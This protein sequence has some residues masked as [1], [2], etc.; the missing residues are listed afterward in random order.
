[1]ASRINRTRA[2][3]RLLC[4]VLFSIPTAVAVVALSGA[5]AANAA[6]GQLTGLTLV[7]TVNHVDLHQLTDNS[8]VD[9]DDYTTSQ[10][11]IRADVTS[12]DGIGS[13]RLELTGPTSKSQTENW[14]PFSLYGDH[15][16]K[17]KGKQLTAGDYRIEATAYSEP[18]LGGTAL[19]TLSVS[20]TLVETPTVRA[21]RLADGTEH[22]GRLEIFHDGQWGTVC[23]DY[24]GAADVAVACRQ[25]GYTKG[26][27]NHENIYPFGTGPIWLDDVACT[28]SE[29][30]LSECRHRAYGANNCFHY[31]DMEITCANPLL[32]I[33][34]RSTILAPENRTLVATLEAVT[35][36]SGNND[37]TWT[38]TGGEDSG[39]FDL[40]S[41]GVLSFRTLQD[42]EAPDDSDSDGRYEVTVQV[43]GGGESA[44]AD[45]TVTLQASDDGGEEVATPL[46]ATFPQSTY[47]TSRHTGPTDR[48]QVVVAFSEA[49]TTIAA[50]TPSAVVTGATVDALAA[51]TEDGL[52]NAWVFFLTPEGNGD[53]TFTLT[54]GVACD[55][56]GICTAAGTTLTEV[57]APRTVPGPGGDDGEGTSS[58]DLT[59]SFSSMPSEHGGPGKL[60]TFELTFNEAPQ[61]GYEKLRDHAFTVSGG[62]VR[63][64]QRL[65]RPSNIRWLITVEP[66]GWGDVSLTLPGGRACTATGAICTDD[67]RMLANSPNA[68]VQGSAALYVAD[69]NAVEGTD[70]MLDFAVILDRASTL[71]VTVDYAT[72]NGTATEDEDYTATSGR[73]TFAPGDIAK[74]VSVPVLNDAKDEGHQETM[75]LTLSNASNARIADGTATGTIANS[76]PLQQAWIARFGRTVASEIVDGITDRLATTGGGSE[77]RIAGVTL[78]RDGAS[79]TE[80]D[81]DETTGAGDTLEGERTMTGHELLMRSAFR[82]QGRSDTPGGTA[83]TAWGRFSSASFEG[84]TEGVRLSGDVTTGILGADVG[85]DDWIAGVAL[86]AAKGDGPFTLANDMPSNRN[87]GAVDSSLTSVHPYAQVNV[88]ERVA[89]WAIGGYGAG[90]MTISEDGGR[91]I[92]T[93]IDMTMAAVGVRGE[94]LDAGA[95]DALDLALRSDALWLHTTSDATPEMV[96]AKAD[97]T[98]LRLMF[99][100]SRGFAGAG[101]GTLTPSIEAGVRRDAGDAEE[102][103]G[104]ELGAGL[105]YQGAG[106]TIEGKVRTLVAHDDS[107]YE[108]WGASASVR[109]DPA[110][111]GRGMSLTLT[112]TWGNAASEA[113]QLW[114]AR[115]AGGLVRNDDFEAESRLETELG[116]GLGAPRGRGVITPYTGLTLADAGSR[117]WRG[118]ARWKVSGAASLSLEGT[119]EERG[120]DEA[121]T[122]A[123]ML[124]ASLRF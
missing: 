14:K 71:T 48:P 10:F 116:Y 100:A 43:A 40:T 32:R 15:S 52:E 34:T 106:I 85:T 23:D 30:A 45:L 16:G 118:G 70:A 8:V 51:H 57:P 5:G 81:G 119:R 78:E 31:E 35:G 54:A 77:V 39:K 4:A 59:A 41:G 120:R 121:S 20:F 19:Q 98:R 21:I 47:S 107:A 60:F 6:T 44:E 38:I 80:R 97:V 88:T 18:G 27:I 113:E 112:P 109:V 13:V 87:T 103:T 108:E 96:A 76:D 73:L 28:G 111:D 79:W 58:T 9:L 66:F 65:E 46:S 49:V 86:S 75:T 56:G 105:A 90:D 64:A 82:L 114:S 69:A 99:D 17:I 22:S 26:T 63:M 67:D 122:N 12:A 68:T 55:A 37:L 110:A 92:K 1:M 24:F 124:R 104:F 3:I 72:S 61:V 95:G 74:T 84:E 42:F 83:W 101:G 89:L 115:D 123:L 93:D 33:V 2:A 62:E 117:T 7:D 53:V 25:L 91:P 94:V 36:D 29:F 50:T 11:G 102:G